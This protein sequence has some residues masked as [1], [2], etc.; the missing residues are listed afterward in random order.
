MDYFIDGFNKISIGNIIGF[1]ADSV[2]LDQDKN[3][4]KV[5]R[6]FFHVKKINISC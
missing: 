3:V 5:E 2:V 4:L 6:G 1:Q